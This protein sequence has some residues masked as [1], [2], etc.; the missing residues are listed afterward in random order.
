MVGLGDQPAWDELS[1]SE[2]EGAPSSRNNDQ[3]S[4]VV[5]EDEEEDASE[6]EDEASEE[7]PVASDQPSD[8]R[9][10]AEVV[11][12]SEEGSEVMEDSEHGSE[13]IEEQKEEDDSNM[14]E[15]EDS[16]MEEDNDSDVEEHDERC[17]QVINDKTNQSDD[18]LEEQS[19]S[20]EEPEPAED[21]GANEEVIAENAVSVAHRNLP[22][23]TPG[24]KKDAVTICLMYQYVEPVWTAKQHKL[25]QAFVI[26]LAKTH[27][28]TGRGRCAPEGLNCTLTGSAEG[29]RAFCYGLREWKPELFNQTDFKLTD[30]LEPKER[31]KAFS[32]R[33]VLELVNYGL[34]GA[35]APSLK[36][37]V[38]THLEATEYHQMMKNP[39]AVII[40]VRNAYESAIGHFAPPEGGAE[41]IDPKMRNSSD[42]PKWLNA[43]ETQAKLQGKD[44]MMYCTGG[45]RCERATALLNQITDAT[46][47]FETKGVTMVRGGIE[48]YLK[49]FPEGGF[50][51]G[52]NF[53]FDKRQEQVPEAKSE[54]RLNQDV[55]SHCCVCNVPWASYHGNKYKCANASQSFQCGVPVLVCPAC[56]EVATTKPKT[57]RCPLCVEGYMAPKEAPDLIRQK[58]QLGVLD[59]NEPAAAKRSK[60]GSLEPSTR[61]FVGRIPLAM[62]FKR[63]QKALKAELAAV[64]WLEDHST[65]RFYGSAFVGLKCLRDAKSVHWQANKKGLKFSKKAKPLKVV[66]APLRPDEQWPQEG[67]V[68]SQYPPVGE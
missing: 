8:T 61:L 3:F 56:T 27:N 58:R 68:Q 31:F 40:D 11:E 37:H 1:S 25:A 48:R 50:W 22:P 34:V 41:L 9:E 49:T 33:K 30:G 52:K 43:P 45:I 66:F 14:E 36:H 44:V 2:E 24:L 65:G 59:A 13:S 32:L 6:S 20:S 16:D 55:E 67:F 46:T 35:K 28:V 51:K 60:T 19:E 7:D 64:D 18:D 29:M 38:G 39:N 57:L 12:H 53:L 63:L 54:A 10:P 42:F 47:G 62:S 17:N 5:A 23:V 26:N 21:L 15:D 4:A